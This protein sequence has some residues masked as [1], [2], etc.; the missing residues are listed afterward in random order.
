MRLDAYVTDCVFPTAEQKRP[1]SPAKSG[2]TAD[3]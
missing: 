3:G 2:S 1:R